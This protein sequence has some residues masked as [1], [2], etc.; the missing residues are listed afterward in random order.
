MDRVLTGEQSPMFFGS[1]MTNFGVELFLKRFLTIG[2]K[3]SSRPMG[4]SGTCP[5][6]TVPLVLFVR[7][8]FYTF[9]DNRALVGIVFITLVCL[10]PVLLIFTRL[11]LACTSTWMGTRYRGG[12]LLPCQS[13]RIRAPCHEHGC[14][15]Y[16]RW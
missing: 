8:V 15:S 14:A 9:M 13:S 6:R 12:V 10:R 4:V 5:F 11:I 3:P 7:R 1:A 2:Q 16:V